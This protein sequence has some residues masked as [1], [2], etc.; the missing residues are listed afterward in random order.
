MPA[1]VLFVLK[2]VQRR[3]A[4]ACDPFRRKAPAFAEQKGGSGFLKHF[5]LVGGPHAAAML[6]RTGAVGA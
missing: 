1:V 2:P 4:P 3:V 5:D 6:T